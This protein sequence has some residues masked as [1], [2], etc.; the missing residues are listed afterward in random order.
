MVIFTRTNKNNKLFQNI[1]K[2]DYISINLLNKYKDIIVIYKIG[3]VQY[4][5][6][7]DFYIRYCFFDK[8]IEIIYFN[9]SGKIHREHK[10]AIISYYENGEIRKEEYRLYDNLRRNDGPAWIKYYDNGRTYEIFKY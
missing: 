1:K 4:K 3:Y 2:Y 9:Y 6:F 10:P 5:K 7:K 8:L